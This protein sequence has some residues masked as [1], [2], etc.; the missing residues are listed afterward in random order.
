ML[1]RLLLSREAA[2]CSK[3]IKGLSPGFEIW[4]CSP[5]GLCGSGR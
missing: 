5:D 3:L 4:L 2:A 1:E